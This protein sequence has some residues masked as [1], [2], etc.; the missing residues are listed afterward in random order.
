MYNWKKEMKFINN[1]LSLLHL[2]NLYLNK[3]DF[4]KSK[5]KL[6]N[7]LTRLSVVTKTL[8]NSEHSSYHKEYNIKIKQQL[9]MHWHKNLFKIISN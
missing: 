8:L 1:H 6:K 5:Q 4:F 7:N 9:Q 2:F 3:V